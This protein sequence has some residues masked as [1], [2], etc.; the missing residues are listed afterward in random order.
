MTSTSALK[1]RYVELNLHP[2]QKRWPNINGGLEFW[3]ILTGLSV[4]SCRAARTCRCLHVHASTY[5]GV[6]SGLVTAAVQL[7]PSWGWF[8]DNVVN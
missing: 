2:R 7:I 6:Y 1:Q 3:C 8:E 5:T 4:G